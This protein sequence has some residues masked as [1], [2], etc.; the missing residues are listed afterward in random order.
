MDRQK[1]NIWL[2]HTTAVPVFVLKNY[3]MWMW[4]NK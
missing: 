2:R 1:C 4:W 3:L